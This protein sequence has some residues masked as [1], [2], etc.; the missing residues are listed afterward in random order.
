MARNTQLRFLVIGAG[1]SGILAAVKLRE[2]GFDD[3]VVLEKADRLGGTWRENRYTGLTCDVPAHAYTYSFAPN[4]EWT[5][6]FAGGD[7]IQT[8]LERVARERRVTPLIRFNHEVVDLDFVDGE[9]TAVTS[10]GDRFAGDV[11]IVASGVLHH[12]RMP[13]IDGLESFAGVAM[14]SAR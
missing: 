13:Q 5:R 2:S 14:H 1:M 10:A 7:E 11:V 4:A 8:Y 3:V 9:W 12:P 6:F